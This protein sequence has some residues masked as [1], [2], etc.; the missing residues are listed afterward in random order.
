MPVVK[1]KFFTDDKLSLIS[2]ENRQKYEKYYL[3]CTIRCRD[4]KET[5]YKSYKN[6]FYHFMAYLAI[7][8]NNIGLYSKEFY[9]NSVD[10][11]ESYISFCQNTLLN[12]KKVINNKLS[13]VS[14]FYIW[15]LKRGLVNSH[16]FDNK[17]ERMKNANEEH[18]INSYFLTPEQTQKIIHELTSNNRYDIQDQIIFS[19]MYD[20]A[21]RIGAI[22]KLTLSS[23]NLEDMIFT[24]IREKRGYIVD[25]IFMP[26]TKLLIE[27]WLEKRKEVDNLTVDSIFITKHNGSYSRMS[28]STLQVRINKIGEIVGIS[29]FH[30]HCIRKSRLSAIYDDT[31]DL[32]LAAELGNHKSTETTRA[33]Y[34]RPKSKTE[35][36]NKLMQ[37]G[38]DLNL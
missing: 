15:S 19:L 7:Y 14:S 9:D 17:L 1:V 5:T 27:K 21:N 26:R 10:I 20:S 3:S 33:F 11:M 29:D 24:G 13:A 28:K 25:V 22:N 35:L 31:G 16:P 12:H 37:I 32:A 34:L 6:S 18:I 38:K 23:L 4:V 30:S 8:H 2:E 36:R